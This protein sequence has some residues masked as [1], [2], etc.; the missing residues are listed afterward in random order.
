MQPVS[1]SGTVEVFQY[2]KQALYQRIAVDTELVFKA[3]G[4]DLQYH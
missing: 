3:D 2:S 1:A 4:A